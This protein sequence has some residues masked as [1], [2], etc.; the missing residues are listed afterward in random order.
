MEELRRELSHR[1]LVL[2]AVALCVG[3]TAVLHPLNLLFL[4]PLLVAKRPVS[5]ALAFLAGL[6]LAPR[7]VAV[8]TAPCWVNG[9]AT[10]LSV[11]YRVEGGQ[12]A[13]V[14][15]GRRKLRALFPFNAVVSRG[16][17]WQLQGKATPLGEA[18]EGLAL[19]GVQGRLRPIEMAKV[20]DGPWPWRLADEWRR[21]F[22]TFTQANL[23][24]REAR[25]LNALTF[26]VDSLDEGEMDALKDTGTVHL[27]AS[28]G[29][30]VAALA[31]LGMGA[32]ALVGVSR[33]YALG[34]VLALLLFYAMATGLHLPTLRAVLA[35]AAGSSAYLVRREPDGLS[36]L[37][38]AALIYLPFDPASIYGLG[39]QLSV[40]V[41]GF[42]ILWPRR[43]VEPARAAAEWFRLHARDLVAVSLIATLS[44][45]P[46][47]ALHQGTATLMS[48]PANLLAVVPAMLSIT[49]ALAAHALHLGFAMPFVGGLVSFVAEV[50]DRTDNV[51]GTVLSVAPFSA[52]WL[53][54]FYV[55]W[56]AFW[57]PR[58]RPCE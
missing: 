32:C 17:V 36:T 50:V 24:D 20:A 5:I 55:L 38:L 15:V 23:R 1:P 16:E 54:P 45:E 13:D 12:A 18:A 37:A 28:S 33:H 53:V 44:A 26:R 7:P 29:I 21:S 49:V 47:L 25:W 35:F 34:L 3:L 58:A 4:L 6:T 8:I 56:I 9:Q 30:H 22:E 2:M 11:P 27:I 39:F 51:P 46:I 41:V 14:Q 43:D 48:V 10:I 42:L 19:K 31:L 52:Y 57:R 40:T